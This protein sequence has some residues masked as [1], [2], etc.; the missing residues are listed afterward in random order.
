M[1]VAQKL[2]NAPQGTKLYSSLFGEVELVKVIPSQAQNDYGS[3]IVV[4]VLSKG[5]ER[6]FLSNGKY[7]DYADAECTLFPSKDMR[8]WAYVEFRKEPPEGTICLVSDAHEFISCGKI[9]PSYGSIRYY[10]GD[11]TCAASMERGDV[12]FHWL[13]IIPMDKIDFNNLVYNKVDD[14]GKHTN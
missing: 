6:A 9:N 11:R 13:H 4:K 5:T 14:Y 8:N 7:Y 2:L 10:R 1:N 12:S 3:S